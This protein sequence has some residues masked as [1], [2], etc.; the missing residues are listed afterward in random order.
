MVVNGALFLGHGAALGVFFTIGSHILIHSSGKE[1]GQLG[2]SLIHGSSTVAGE[3]QC[4][5][6]AGCLGTLQRLIGCIDVQDHRGLGV[7]VLAGG[8]VTIHLA[9]D[10]IFAVGILAILNTTD[11]VV[12]K[13]I[14]LVADQPVHQVGQN[15]VQVPAQAAAQTD[16]AANALA[17]F[18]H[19]TAQQTAQE[20]VKGITLLVEYH[21]DQHFVNHNGQNR[22]QLHNGFN[23][24][25]IQVHPY[26]GER[27]FQVN[28]GLYQFVDHF[29]HNRITGEGQACDGYAFLIL[30]IQQHHVLIDGVVYS[31][32]SKGILK[33]VFRERIL[34]ASIRDGLGIGDLKVEINGLVNALLQ[35]TTVEGL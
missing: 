28:L 29:V 20:T 4:I 3:L 6:N 33:T 34:S 17:V 1:G 9:D 15:L 18:I 12:C 13:V 11:V 35:F 31:S 10:H 24:V 8:G 14:V 26:I 30:R 19:Q 7:I 32:N 22:Q 16:G 2:H 5:G 25:L 23:R 27:A 21:G